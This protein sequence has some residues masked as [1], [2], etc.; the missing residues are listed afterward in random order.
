MILV[1]GAT[2]M[3]GGEV[4]RLLAAEGKEVRALVR[5]SS[6]P[7]KVARLKALGVGRLS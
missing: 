7:E 6:N 5:A 4:C 1:V 3:V 2:G